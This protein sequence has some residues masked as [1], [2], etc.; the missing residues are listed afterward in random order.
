MK[1]KQSVINLIYTI[2]FGLMIL[3]ILV[4]VPL[5]TDRQI[6]V[7]EKID[8]FSEGWTLPGGEKVCA[9]DLDI[10]DYDGRVAIEKSSPM[11]SPI[12]MHCALNLKTPT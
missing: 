10:G 8:G 6:T 9:D 7:H 5:S 3:S 2:I 12:R 11:A 1:S 4:G